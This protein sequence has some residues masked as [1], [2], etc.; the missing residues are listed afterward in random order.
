MA[1]LASDTFN[2]A[3]SGDLGTNWTQVPSEFSFSI[4]GNS[5][6]P[7]NL[8]Q[9]CT[10]RYSG[11]TWPDDQ[12][13]QCVLTPSTTGGAAN[14]GIG[15]CLRAASADQTYYRITADD[16][17]ASNNL[18]LQKM[19]AGAFTSVWTRSLAIT[20]GDILRAEAQ[21]TTVRVYINGVQLGADTTDGS[22]ASGSAGVSYS[23]QTGACSVDDWEGGDFASPVTLTPA[24]AVAALT[25][26]G[27]SLGFTINMP[28]EA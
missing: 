5:A 25:G 16:T 13:S 15:V 2:R 3:D 1:V 8:G 6:I 27:V 11:L 10:E 28:D 4:S 20:A 23:S 21:G 18:S 14:E 22:I 26:L 17:S 19:V 9:D 12:Y 7:G 24:Q